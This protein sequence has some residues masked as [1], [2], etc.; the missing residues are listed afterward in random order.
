MPGLTVTALDSRGVL[1]EPRDVEL[2]G[3]ELAA[4]REARES[5]LLRA[6]SGRPACFVTESPQ[7][8]S[9]SRELAE[10]GDVVAG[11][12]VVEATPYDV[13]FVAACSDELLAVVGESEDFERGLLWI[14][15]LRAADRDPLL[16]LIVE[17]RR[18]RVGVPETGEEALLC[19]NDGEAVWWL[20][21]N[22]SAD[23]NREAA[24]AAARA[25]RW[26][27]DADGVAAIAD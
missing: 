10:R 26:S 3:E 2:A 19:A 6:Y 1:L 8:W 27:V 13:A 7:K 5:F 4:W 21:P 25:V 14:A 23:E 22:R 18:D 12:E 24:A 16:A 17:L 20:N 9:V 11:A 15:S